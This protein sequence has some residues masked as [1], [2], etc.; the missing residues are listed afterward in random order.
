MMAQQFLHKSSSDESA[1]KK[2]ACI[3]NKDIEMLNKNKINYFS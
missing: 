3:K 1:E 2:L